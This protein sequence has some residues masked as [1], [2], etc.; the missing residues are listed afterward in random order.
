[1]TA[2]SLPWSVWPG[3]AD[4]SDTRTAPSDRG[5]FRRAT[6]SALEETTQVTGPPERRAWMR[7]HRMQIEFFKPERRR[8]RSVLHRRDG[9]VIELD[10]GSYNKVGRAARELPHDLAHFVVEDGLGLEAGP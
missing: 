2:R 8:Y 9:L 5:A 10:G 6:L 3:N 7:E 1:M 4:S